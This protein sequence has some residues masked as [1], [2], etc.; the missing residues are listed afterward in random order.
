MIRIQVHPAFFFG[1]GSK[2]NGCG[3]GFVLF[4]VPHALLFFAVCLSQCLICQVKG[5][6]ETSGNTTTSKPVIYFKALLFVLTVMYV[7]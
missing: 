1:D 4:S 7:I 2:E 3:L 5:N 6:T